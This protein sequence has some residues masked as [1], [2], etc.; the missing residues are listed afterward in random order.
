MF[1]HHLTLIVVPSVY[2]MSTVNK[3][4]IVNN[5]PVYHDVVILSMHSDISAQPHSSASMTL[6][7]SSLVKVFTSMLTSLQ[8][9]FAPPM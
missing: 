1:F 5:I 6:M 3:L 9:S 2:I 4:N 7:T 8:S